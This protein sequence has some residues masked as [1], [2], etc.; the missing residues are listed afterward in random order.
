MKK[1]RFRYTS[2]G[3]IFI[4]FPIRTRSYKPSKSITATL[5][6]LFPHKAAYFMHMESYT[7]LI[8]YTPEAPFG[9]DPAVLRKFFF[10]NLEAAVE[11]V[12]IR[13]AETAF[14][15]YGGGRSVAL[16]SLKENEHRNAGNVVV[17]SLEEFH[18]LYRAV[19][20][21]EMVTALLCSLFLNPDNV[22][23]LHVPTNTPLKNMFAEIEPV[24]KYLKTNITCKPYHP[25]SG[26]EFELDEPVGFRSNLIAFSDASYVLSPGTG[27]LF[28]FPYWNRILEMKAGNF[29]NSEPQPCNNCL[30]CSRFCPVG[31]FPSYLYHNI[32]HDN[33]DEAERLGLKL[34][35]QCGVCQFVCPASLPLFSTITGAMNENGDQE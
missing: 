31:I 15:L 3:E 24:S 2:A 4:P 16:K 29:I 35:I 20:H 11:E 27:P 26:Q 34:C 5:C 8:S 25:I 17:L 23:T 30:S 6:S 33:Y 13:Y 10:K 19:I 7:F 12:Q 32:N 22:F 21:E 28:G 1:L 14:L 18:A 9:P